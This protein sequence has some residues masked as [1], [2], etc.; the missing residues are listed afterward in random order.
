MPHH[1]LDL[2]DPDASFSVAEFVTHATGV[3][4]ALHERRGIAILAGG[5]GL[6]LRSVARGLDADAL[7]S[8]ADRARP[9]RGG[10]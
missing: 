1:G 8:D 10:A 3:L 9:A 2:V 6:Y 5:T 7:P 4:H